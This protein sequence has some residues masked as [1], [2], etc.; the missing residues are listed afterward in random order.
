MVSDAT[1][2][3][4]HERAELRRIKGNVS[5][6]CTLIISTRYSSVNHPQVFTSYDCICKPLLF[7]NSCR[8]F[9]RP[10][11]SVFNFVER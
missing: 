2:H 5:Q 1:L 11:Y 8:W 9:R 6:N 10:K 4:T 7:I 3:Q